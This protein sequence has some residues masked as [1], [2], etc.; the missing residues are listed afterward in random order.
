MK[1]IKMTLQTNNKT[2]SNNTYNYIEN[3]NYKILKY[4]NITLKFKLNKD[5]FIFIRETK[6]D[7][8]KIEKNK[9]SITLK[10]LNTTFDIPLSK[11]NYTKNDNTYTITYSIE[12]DNNEIKIKL[13][14]L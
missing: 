13:K 2:I 4:D 6:E 8:F 9:G 14:D 7:I 5:N 3:N 11:C 1:K 12:E 10:E